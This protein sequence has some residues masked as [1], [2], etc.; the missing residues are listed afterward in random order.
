MSSL[1]VLPLEV[2][3]KT[4]DQQVHIILQSN[5]EFSGKL[6]GFDEFVNVILEDPIEYTT[7]ITANDGLKSEVV[8]EHHGRML[9]SGN[10]ITMLV[11][12]GKKL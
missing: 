4:I 2:I 9:L 11:P 10:N 12:G 8:M 7:E 3:H 6:V 5:R 1:D